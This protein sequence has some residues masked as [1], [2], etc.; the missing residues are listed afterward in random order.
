MKDQLG[1]KHVAVEVLKFLTNCVPSFVYST[2]TEPQCTEW[3]V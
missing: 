3:K 1:P 2:V